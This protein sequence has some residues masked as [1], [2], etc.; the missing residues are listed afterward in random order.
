LAGREGFVSRVGARRAP[1][2]RSEWESVE[3][4]VA[5]IPHSGGQG[6]WSTHELAEFLALVASHGDERAAIQRGIERAAEVFEAEATALVRSGA[7]VA[8]VGFPARAR[9]DDALVAA[10]EGRAGSLY[11]SGVGGCRAISMPLEDERPVQLVVARSGDEAFSQEE[12]SLLRGMGQVLTLGLRTLR[13]LDNERGL[14]ERE[15]G[16]A[17][18][19]ARLVEEL[20]ERQ[21]LLERLSGIQRLIVAQTPLQDV[22]EEIAEAT[23]ELLGDELVAIRLIDRDEPSRCVLTA[24]RGASADR[25]EHDRRLPSVEG[26]GGRA[27]DGGRVVTALGA[28][29]ALACAE[30]ATDGSAAAIVAPLYERGRP[31]G[32]LG[33][34]TRREGRDYSPRDHRLVLALAELANLALNHARAIEDVAHEAF[35]DAVTGLPNRVLFRDRAEHALSRNR[36][37]PREACVLFID[38]DGFKTIN[39]SLGPTAGDEL[40]LSVAR[41]LSERLG[42]GDTLARLGGDEF[43]VLLEEVEG[44]TDAARAAGRVLDV[45]T[46]PFELKGREVFVSASIGIAVGGVDVDELL[47]NADL[48]MYRAKSRGRARYEVFEPTMHT[49]VFERLE[50]EHDLTRAIERNELELHFQPIFDLDAKQV[51][52]L[53]ALVRWRHPK[54]GLIGPEAFIPL[55]EETGQVIEVGQWVLSAACHR[56][57]LWRA[58][59]PAYPR[60]QVCVNLSGVE[61]QEPG[62]A[63]NVEAALRASQLDSSALVLEMTETVLMD[64]TEASV[65]RLESLKELGVRLVMDDFGTGY[66]SLRYLSR[67]PLDGLKI[68]RSFTS[69]VGGPREEPA[70]VRAIADLGRIFGLSVVAEGVERP[71]QPARLL[72]LGCDFGQGH[73]FSRPL[74]AEEADDMLLRAGLLGPPPETEPKPVAPTAPVHV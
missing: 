34:A 8:S 29:A 69:K 58:K 43:A 66:S 41:R 35:H 45:F 9:P 25:I 10:A 65:R 72:D 52:A 24:S 37:T 74:P 32:S 54:R 5:Q 50:L 21:T 16:Q 63:R 27:R 6:S 17:R 46:Q 61:L 36:R 57:A 31:A 67:F 15:E 33:A 23:R 71:E 53:E 73:H 19:N 4:E 49:A 26:L 68:E 2:T 30:F 40:L 51:S 64:D 44:H 20:R 14:R 60:L 47:R 12:I 48:A 55:A 56:A 62:L 39:D 1:A 13:L 70:L 28:E 7:V 22:L 18:E 11:V 59:Y 42:P 3:R 38:L